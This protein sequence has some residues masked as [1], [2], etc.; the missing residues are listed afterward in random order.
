MNT[1]A[2][3]WMILAWIAWICAIL[4]LAFRPFLRILGIFRQ[5]DPKLYVAMLAAL[6]AGVV[7]ASA[8]HLLR[9]RGF[10]RWEP[11]VLP[12]ALLVLCAIY[13]P[14]GV[15]MTLWLASS[16]FALGKFAA[17]QVGV[18]AGIELSTLGGLGIFSVVLFVL[19][20]SHAFYSWVFLLLL[21]L[22]LPLLWKY[23]RDVTG[24]L[25]ALHT[26][27][28]SDPE[29]IAPH[30]SVA[31]F[32]AV[33]LALITAATSLTPAW[34]G[35]TVEFHIPLI[36]VFF[37]SHALTVPR[38]I[39]YGYFP[40][41]FE[42]LA[43]MSYA[44]VGQI[45]AQ[46]VNPL[47]FCLSIAVLYR[48]ARACGISRSW[49]IAGLVLGISIPF[50]HWTGSV[51]KN[52]IPLAGYELAALLCW[53]RWRETQLFRWLA[54]SAFF[55]AMSFDIKHVA[56]FGAIPWALAVAYSLWRQ[57]RK[58]S[59]TALL[60]GILILFGSFWQLRAYVATGNPIAPEP[61]R[62]VTAIA[63]SG[64]SH[65]RHRFWLF[66]GYNVHFHGRANFQSPT[67]NPAGIVLLLLAPLWLI[68]R[69]AGTNWGAEAVLWLFVLVYYPPW[70][71][72]AAILR[73]AVAPALL[74]AVLGVARLALFPR[75][76]AVSAMSAALLFSLPVVIL[77]EMAPAQ[78][79]LFLKQINAATFLR[80][81][82][83]PYGA[84][85]FLDHHATAS[86]SIASVGDWA[87]AY[88]PNPANFHVFY[89]NERLYNPGSV[90]MLLKPEDRYL[91]LP[92]Q[93]NLQTLESAAGDDFRFSRV[94]QDRDFVVDT[95]QP[96]SKGN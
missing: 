19:G 64:R 66:A 14:A 40:Q 13:S 43:M 3:R 47:F 29:L 32:A 94:Y 5:V 69:A 61:L 6:A 31:M 65:H 1:L 50:V 30:V 34:N 95:V 56:L 73:Y 55:I 59:R 17:D 88:A 48:I 18:R 93:P 83:P 25:R 23:F 60:A 76:L 52:D 33:L 39:P 35:D 77:I 27:W 81:T 71:V 72:E 24:E 90:R 87:A 36:R 41:G 67:Q 53:F 85:E 74:L 58:F 96:L 82:L 70:A 49:A 28:V 42:V 21:L 51:T 45:A 7:A 80:R 91:I 12:G 9:R 54:V 22:P 79:P 62:L 84:V 26:A 68:R 16:A 44:F 63:R 38:A 8:Y 75:S 2:P 20:M 86:D 89:L 15:A 4:A 37:A 11:I 46:F 92:A 10:W 57:P 78:I